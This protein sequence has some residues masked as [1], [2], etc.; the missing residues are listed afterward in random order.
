MLIIIIICSI[1]ITIVITTNNSSGDKCFGR[2]KA[3]SLSLATR[4]ALW[5]HGSHT[6]SFVLT[7]FV[8]HTYIYIYICIL[9]FYVYIYIYRERERDIDICMCIY[10]YLSLYLSLSLYIYTHKFRVLSYWLVRVCGWGCAGAAA[11]PVREH[12]LRNFMAALLSS[13]LSL[14]LG[15]S[16]L[17]VSW[18]L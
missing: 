2:P 1:T 17:L 4:A 9:L 11:V 7:N 10:T 18:L 12:A 14:S 3:L 6:A 13:I 15:L 16:L 8:L 5:A